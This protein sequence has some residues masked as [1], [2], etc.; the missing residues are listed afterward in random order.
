M[1]Q[2]SSATIYFIDGG[3]LY[4]DLPAD[5]GTMRFVPQGAPPPNPD[6]PAGEVDGSL[7]Y[8]VSFGALGQEQ[9]VL[10]GT[11]I[12]AD[13]ANGQITGNAG[14][15]NY[16]GTLTPVNDYFVVEGIITTRKFCSEPA[17]VMEQE[18]AYLAALGSVTGYQWEQGVVND[19]TVATN[20]LVTYNLPDGSPGVMN[21]VSSQ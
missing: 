6:T 3:N 13:F 10:A 1:N 15:N 8:L 14:C 18:Q 9:V 20:I 4:M 5:S 11:Q 12:T 16:S 2:L 21:F 19:V 17:G 7:F